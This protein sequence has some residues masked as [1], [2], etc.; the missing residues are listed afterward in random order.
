MS[1]PNPTA[2]DTVYLSALFLRSIGG[3]HPKCETPGTVE[4]VEDGWLAHVAWRDGS[5]STVNVGNLVTV[6]NKARE[7]RKVETDN[8][9]PGITIGYRRRC[10]VLVP[11]TLVIATIVN[12]AT[13]YAFIC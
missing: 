1:G 2:G 8:L 6:A 7:A 12:A 5:K 13:L 3:T 4:R 10:S 9:A 11:L